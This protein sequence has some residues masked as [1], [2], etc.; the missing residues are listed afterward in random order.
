MNTCTREYDLVDLAILVLACFRGCESKTTAGFSAHGQTNHGKGDSAS[1][2]F[3][4]FLWCESLQN[5]RS[6]ISKW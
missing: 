2:Y 3:P 1:Q 4:W 6:G 5:R